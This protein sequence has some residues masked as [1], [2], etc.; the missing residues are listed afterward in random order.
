MLKNQRTEDQRVGSA[1]PSRTLHPAHQ[2]GIYRGFDGERG[3][4]YFHVF[5][6]RNG[7]QF[8]KYFGVH[9]CG[10]EKTAMALAQAWRDMIIAQH[11]PMTIAQFCAIVRGNNTSGVPGVYRNQK[12]Y[13]TKSGLASTPYWQAR[14]PLADGKHRMANFSVR[15]LGEEEAKTRAIAARLRGLEELG[16]TVFRAT[17]QPQPVSTKDD[18]AI[19]E[20]TLRAHW[21]VEY[22]ETRNGKPNG[23]N[24]KSAWQRSARK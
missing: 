14:I 15:A 21:S 11:P 3:G 24:A 12:S 4:D 17:R 8:Q 2:I 1:N 5:L 9:R 23:H 10:G 22:C 13:R 20:S 18:I 16:N 7:T 19:L 6:L